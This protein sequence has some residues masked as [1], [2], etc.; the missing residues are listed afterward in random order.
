MPHYAP[1][2]RD[3]QFVLHEML[4]VADAF[5]ALPRHAAVDA[6]TVNAVLEEAGRFAAQVVQPLNAVGDREGCALDHAT[7]EVRTPTGY[8]AAYALFVQGGWPSLSCDIEH[9]GQGLPHVLNQCLYEMLNSASQAWSMYPGLSRG[10]YECLS[11]HGTPAQKALYLPRLATGEWSGTMCLTEPHCGTDLGLLR[12]K[13][14][15]LADGRYRITGQKVFIS[16]GE[17]DLAANIVHLVLARLPAAP[18]GSKGL[19]LF[20]VPKFLPAAD[21][22]PGARNALGCTGLERKMGIHGNATCRMEFEGAVGELVGRAHQG[23]PAMFVM[24]NAA[25]LGVGVQSLGLTE[26]AYQNAAGYARQRLQMR[27]LSGPKAPQ[28]PADPILVH[29]DVRRM[30]LSARAWAE[31]ARAL[32]LF[33]ALLMDQSHAATDA[34]QAR[35]A[36]QLLGLLTPV[37]KAFLSENAWSAISQCLQVL[38]GHGYVADFGLEQFLRD[39]RINMIYE[40]ANGVQAL[41]LLGMKVLADGG[42]RL[43]ALALRVQAL[44]QACAADAPMQEFTVPLAQLC[45]QVTQLTQELGARALRDRDE[46]GAAAA[47]YLRLCGHLVFAW[48]FAQ[49]ARIALREQHAE[50]FYRAKLCT[51]RFYFARLLPETQSLLRAARAGAAP[52]MALDNELF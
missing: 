13:A 1:P 2:L 46:I 8:K 39:A 16:S 52:L 40:G 47:D 18:P 43:R 41:D 38:G 31:G 11:V 5:K 14:Q 23:L 37:M 15:P 30:L 24:M 9:G 32:A 7:H 42:A 3:M 29:P 48:L 20:L 36:E 19:S 49:Q 10:A 25:R 34:Q 28:L 33:S 4:G 45:E 17:H 21:G 50:A 22:R 51:I 27:S 6:D 12:T 44:V 26:V 35:E